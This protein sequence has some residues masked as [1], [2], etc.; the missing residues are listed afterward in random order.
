MSLA[1]YMLSYLQHILNQPRSILGYTHSRD[2]LSYVPVTAWAI[3]RCIPGYI[4]RNKSETSCANPSNIND[5][6]MLP[7]SKHLSLSIS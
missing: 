5:C 6:A 2:I 1:W 4:L 3:F 7:F